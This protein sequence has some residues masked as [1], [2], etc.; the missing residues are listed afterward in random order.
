MTTFK[1]TIQIDGQEYTEA[2]LAMY[3][4]Q[5]TIHVLH[6]LKE[7]GADILHNDK[8]LSH[9][10]INFLTTTEAKQLLVATKIEIGTEGLRKLYKEKMQV[11]D[12][13]WLEILRHSDSDNQLKAARTYLKVEGITMPEFQKAFKL[14]EENKKL[15]LT[16]N[17]E[18]FEITGTDKGQDGF[19][20]MGMYGEPTDMILIAD[21]TLALP[22]PILPDYP[23]QISGSEIMAST[24]EKNHV[25]ARHQIKP[26]ENGLELLTAAYFPSG[27]P[28]ELVNGHKIHLALEFSNIF[29][30][31]NATK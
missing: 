21:P 4:Y 28:D 26:T 3:E 25:Y 27:T 10:E 24:G 30:F 16:L 12:Q 8:N 17:P 1:L 15:G 20:T 31:L 7:L 6:E 9:T 22:D 11:M 18:H 5:R 13:K 19:E 23:I 14:V 2:Q 29:K